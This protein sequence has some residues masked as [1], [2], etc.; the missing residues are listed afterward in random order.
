MPPRPVIPLLIALLL[1]AFTCASLATARSAQ[2][3]S[4][5]RTTTGRPLQDPEWIDPETGHRVV[6]WSRLPGRGNT[7]YF[8][9][10]AFTEKGD[11]FV[12]YNTSP[13]GRRRLHSLNLATREITR[14][15]DRDTSW[16]FFPQVAPRA[17][18]LI[19]LSGNQVLAIHLDT[20]KSRLVS[21]IPQEWTSGRGW[22]L[23]SDETL[24]AAC[25]VIGER[26]LTRALPPE[27][28][29]RKTMEAGLH[30]I[31]YTMDLKSGEIRVL[32]ETRKHW[33]GHCQFSP[34]DPALLMYCHEGPWRIVED[35]MWTIRTDTA[36]PVPKPLNPALL[37]G[38][39]AN[40]HEFWDTDGGGVW[41]DQWIYNDALPDSKT[42]AL[43]GRDFYLARVNLSDGVMTHRY[44][45]N[46]YAWS[47]HYAI[48]P[49]RAFF[50]GD[51][52]HSGPG[53]W[54]YRYTPAPGA[55][56]PAKPAFAIDKLASLAG[57]K[58]PLEPNVRF[59][60]D[61]KWIVFQSNASGDSQVYAV[62]LAKP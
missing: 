6:L 37:R 12:F 45:V 31:L 17:R 11:L 49:D 43:G 35:R 47:Y 26:E 56:E 32:L 50:V 13:D 36:N 58:Y 7:L 42:D 59:T 8:H 2:P 14:L 19:V 57:N 16:Y 55:R 51:G 48:S 34:A 9:Q 10:H 28:R 53:S 22:A 4:P 46:K 38:V 30:N 39:E 25:A 52:N 15:N 40:G 24:L 29:L 18:Q 61:G 62:E 23:N 41:F 60:P 33:L 20:Q 27:G 21:T 54:I 1:P 3:S 5:S 44:P